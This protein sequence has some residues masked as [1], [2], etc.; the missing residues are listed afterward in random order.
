MSTTAAGS[1]ASR[2]SRMCVALTV[3]GW[4]SIL[5]LSLPAGIS[6]ERLDSPAMEIQ[7]TPVKA[8]PG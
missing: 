1:A 8:Y 3:A 6:S 4:L 2:A 7:D 5:A